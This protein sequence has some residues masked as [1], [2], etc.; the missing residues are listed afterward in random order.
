[1]SVIYSRWVGI[2][3][4]RDWLD[5]HVLPSG[6]SYRI[7]Y[8]QA[9]YESWLQTQCDGSDEVL[10][11]LESTGGLEKPLHEAIERHGHG[12]ARVNPRQVK[13]FSRALNRAKTDRLDAQTL[14]EYGKRIEPAATPLLC[15]AQQAL[16]DLVM[17]RRQLVEMKSA[18]QN[19]LSRAPQRV[20]QD[21]EAHV[22]ELQGRIQ[23]LDEEIADLQSQN[24]EFCHKAK[25]L[26]SVPGVGTVTAGVCLALLPELGSLDSKRIA[27]LVG[28]APLNHDSGQ[29]SGKRM[30]SGGRS[31][32]RCALYM[33]ALVGIQ[34]NEVLRAF[35]Q[36]L[37]DQGKVKRVALVAVMRKLL[38]ILNALIRTD[39]PWQQPEPEAV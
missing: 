29:K 20:R 36:R 32:V 25:L 16:K 38:T 21:I 18:E 39:K 10:F 26:T 3:V 34:H 31:Q 28:L 35:Y 2:D 37:L 22:K 24:A 30:I 1:M 12:V 19:R 6:T 11:I 8:T 14:A 15:E 13:D 33:A 5:L 7:P 4:S 9:E 17:R 27:R 23:V